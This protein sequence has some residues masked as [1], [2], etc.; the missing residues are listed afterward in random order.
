MVSLAVT[1]S[2]INQQLTAG[3]SAEDSVRLVAALEFVKPLYAG[4]AIITGQDAFAFSQ[5]VVAVLAGLK[6]DAD[7][8]VAGILVRAGRYPTPRP[9]KSSKRASARKSATRWPA[10]AN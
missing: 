6:T 3:L 2:V 4:K 10:S 8:R 7:M 9:P 5:G 1:Q